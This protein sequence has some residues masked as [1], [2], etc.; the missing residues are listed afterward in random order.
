MSGLTTFFYRFLILALGTALLLPSPVAF[1]EETEAIPPEQEKRY[2]WTVAAGGAVVQIDSSY[3]YTDKETGHSFF[4]DPEG[5]LNLSEREYVPSAYVLAL[6]K[7]RHYLLAGYTRFRRTSGEQRLDE[8]LDIGDITFEADASVE[9]QWDSDDFDV[10]YGYRIHKDDRLRILV[11]V[12]IYVLDL[13]ARLLAEG[14]Y[15]IDDVTEAGIF[16][17]EASLVAP[18]P[19]A[20]LLFDFDITRRWSLMTSVEAVYAPVGD[21]TGRALRTR[22]HARAR[23]SKLV[24][25]GFGIS[26]FNIGVVDEDDEEK[27]DIKYGY[28]G[29]YAGLSF[30]F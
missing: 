15:T 10:S 4:I 13:T 22:L 12:G 3:K 29:L 21:I 27:Q 20:G 16:E 19:L 5:Q 25:I 6:I 7:G 8:S 1:A 23:L 18:L 30:N 26:Y 17:E 28:D 14:S 2:R 9:F 24:A 11:Q